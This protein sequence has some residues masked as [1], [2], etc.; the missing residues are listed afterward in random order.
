MLCQLTQEQPAVRGCS[1]R[2][3]AWLRYYAAWLQSYAERCTRAGHDSCRLAAVALSM[4]GCKAVISA[5]LSDS[6]ITALTAMFLSGTAHLHNFPE[7]QLDDCQASRAVMS[8][9][10]K[11]VSQLHVAK[12]PMI[13]PAVDYAWLDSTA[14]PV[15]SNGR[16]CGCQIHTQMDTNRSI[17]EHL[18]LDDPQD[19]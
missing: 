7:Q 18:R 1:L 5:S 6:S 14:E 16:G 17:L 10:R 9:F 15:K 13:E 8:P 4:Y 19:C 3:I 2:V 12:T 11:P